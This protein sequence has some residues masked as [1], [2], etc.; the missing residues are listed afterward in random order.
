M[1]SQVGETKWSQLSIHSMRGVWGESLAHAQ[2]DAL[3]LQ[4]CNAPSFL[5]PGRVGRLWKE[6]IW[7]R[8]LGIDQK[9]SKLL[10]WKDRAT[11]QNRA[12]TA[13]HVV[14]KML[15]QGWEMW[16]SE[17]PSRKKHHLCRICSNLHIP[18]NANPL[19]AKESHPLLICVS[20]I[21]EGSNSNDALLF[22]SKATVGLEIPT[23]RH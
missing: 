19:C 16:V 20:D 11:F 18:V 12:P 6:Q 7:S 2:N 13:S 17:S 22:P 10:T 5:I 1:R 3:H 14:A 9:A 8:R 4:D 21:I 15:P 23:L